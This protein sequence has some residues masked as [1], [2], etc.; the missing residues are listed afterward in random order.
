MLILK[1]LFFAGDAEQRRL[2]ESKRVAIVLY[3]EM[4][5]WQAGAKTHV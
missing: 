2:R 4:C 3:A 1:I 5:S